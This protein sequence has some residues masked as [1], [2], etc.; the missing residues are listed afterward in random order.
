MLYKQDES[1]C[2]KGH[3]TIDTVMTVFVSRR[4]RVEALYCAAKLS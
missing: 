3:T 4:C 1:F 2:R